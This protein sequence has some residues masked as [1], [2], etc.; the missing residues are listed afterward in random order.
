[1][2]ESETDLM[3][4]KHVKQSYSDIYMSVII[5]VGHRLYTIDTDVFLA[6]YGIIAKNI[7]QPDNT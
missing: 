2:E 7:S 3:V 6:I 4:L 5:Y 1:M